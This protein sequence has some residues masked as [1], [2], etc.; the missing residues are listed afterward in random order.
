M[1]RSS[2]L[3]HHSANGR[4]EIHCFFVPFPAI[5]QVSQLHNLVGRKAVLHAFVQ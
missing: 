1:C 5:D 2:K 3:D 4:K